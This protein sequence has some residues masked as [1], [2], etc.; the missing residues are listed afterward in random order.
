MKKL[1]LALF[2]L[3]IGMTTALFLT[4]CGGDSGSSGGDSGGEAA[5][6]A[7]VEED[8][9]E[10]AVAEE[11]ASTKTLAYFNEYVNGGAYTMEMKA[12][13][14]G[15]TATILSAVKDG[16]V[17][18]KNEMDGATSIMIMKGDEQY[19]LD[20]S[21]KTCMKMSV[22]TEEATEMFADEAE[23][24]EVVA[25]SGSEE[26]DGKTYD[27]EEYLVEDTSVKYY[28]D[29]KD[30]KYIVTSMEGESYTAEII[31]LESGADDSLFEIPDDYTML[32]Y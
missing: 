12:D 5:A 16:M 14:Q 18:S 21:T 13:Y 30:L 2:L 17:Y 29:G 6:E 32:E 24:Y 15:T 7:N 27:Y 25:S 11:T 1:T 23:S 10:D 9:D 28:F 3:V 26:V 4:S 20:P 31:S 19:I 22:L 8:T